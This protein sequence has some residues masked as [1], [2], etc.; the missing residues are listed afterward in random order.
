VRRLRRETT[1]RHAEA[2]RRVSEGT[3]SGGQSLW[4]RV[5]GHDQRPGTAQ[6]VAGACDDLFFCTLDVDLEIGTE[7]NVVERARLDL[8]SSHTQH[9]ALQIAAQ[10]ALA[11]RL[12]D[13]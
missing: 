2:I 6:R 12:L 11:G 8:Q 10:A 13:E 5:L 3:E 1:T 4:I 7:L 9:F